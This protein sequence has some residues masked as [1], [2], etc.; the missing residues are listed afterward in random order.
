M[1]NKKANMQFRNFRIKSVD[2][3]LFSEDETDEIKILEGADTLEEGQIK[4]DFNLGTS[5]INNDELDLKQLDIRADI[6]TKTNNNIIKIE[7][8]FNG[9]F[10]FLKEEMDSE[11]KEELLI[12]NGTAI[13]FPYV[14]SFVSM[15]SGFDTN[16]TQI[17]LPTL[18]LSD[19]KPIENK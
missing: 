8:F 14:R 19:V 2:Y 15:I 1:S 6:L 13:L 5:K 4:M 12:R 9:M 7:L 16:N 17:I 11:F 10:E 18:N 3:Q